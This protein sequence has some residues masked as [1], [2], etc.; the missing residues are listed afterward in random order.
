MLLPIAD[1][2]KVN[3]ASFDRQGL[4][5]LRKAVEGTPTALLAEKIDTQEAY[6]FAL[7]EG[8]TYFQGF[9]FCH[10]D[11]IQK[12]KVPSNKFLHIELLRYLRADPM[13]FKKIAPL[14]KRDAALVYRLLKL[15]NS[16]LCA[17]RQEILS[18]EAAIFTMGEETFRRIAML[19]VLSEL[20]AGHPAEILHMVLVRARFCELAAASCEL[21]PEEQYLL[22]MLSLLPAMLR[23]PMEELVEE[24]PLR[25]EIRNALLGAP[26]RERCLLAWIE[27]HERNEVSKAN[28]VADTFGL[29]IQKLEQFHVDAVVWEAVTARAIS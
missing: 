10:P 2:V 22:G 18:I 20:N 28:L 4:E 12:T 7:E 1:Y 8:F 5:R 3:P 14:V 24:L 29:N 9:Y 13:D 27:V 15:V 21:D 6:R 17:M 19:A 11:L 16:P 23:R 25:E 26:T